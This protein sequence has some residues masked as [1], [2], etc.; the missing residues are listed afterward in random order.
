MCDHEFKLMLMNKMKSSL[1]L[2]G[3]AA[4]YAKD[5]MKCKSI[6]TSANHTAAKKGPNQIDNDQQL[7][8]TATNV[9]K[10]L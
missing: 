9:T 5:T 2:A 4:E 8:R 7:N 10:S 3:K 6:L 1:T